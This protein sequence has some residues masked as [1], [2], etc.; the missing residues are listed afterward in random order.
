M[1]KP[2]T[3]LTVDWHDFCFRTSPSASCLL[4][5]RACFLP[6]PP[7]Q[8]TTHRPHVAVRSASRNL[9]ECTPHKASVTGRLMFNSANSNYLLKT[10]FFH[11]C[12]FVLCNQREPATE[13]YYR[14]QHR[15]TCKKKRCLVVKQV[16]GGCS[17]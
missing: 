14:R 10:F 11:Q 5:V 15:G 16:R 1:R 2:T 9:Q 4:P 6:S 12:I 3:L 17:F 8:G 13:G 7:C